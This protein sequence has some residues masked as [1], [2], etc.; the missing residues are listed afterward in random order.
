M[1]AEHG[2]WLRWSLG[3]LLLSHFSRFQISF[4]VLLAETS[5]VVQVCQ[6][7]G[8]LY[9]ALGSGHS[10]PRPGLGLGLKSFESPISRQCGEVEGRS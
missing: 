7:S 5:G 3:F 9:Q 8:D 1:G 4:T 10:E 6:I 2:G